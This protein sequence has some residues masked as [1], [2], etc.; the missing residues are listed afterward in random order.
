MLNFKLIFIQ[1]FLFIMQKFLI[2][3]INFYHK[4]NKNSNILFINKF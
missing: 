2:Y 1:N 3:Q 4:F